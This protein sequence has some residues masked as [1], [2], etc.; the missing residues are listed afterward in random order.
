MDRLKKVPDVVGAIRRAK[1]ARALYDARRAAIDAHRRARITAL[2]DHARRHAPWHAERLA[3]LAADVDVPD[4]PVMD[5]ADLM[6]HFDDAVCDR[7]LRLAR[8]EQHIAELDRDLVL[9]GEYRVLA[10]SG[11][12]GLRGVYVLD[13][14]A[15]RRAMAVYPLAADLH[16]FGP[17]LPR[18]RRIAQLG[19]AGPLH[20]THRLT[21]SIDVGLNRVLRLDVTAP[22]PELC[23]ALQ[24]FDPEVLVGYPSVLAALADEQLD[25]RLDVRPAVV[26]TSSEQLTPGMRARIAAAWTDPFDAYATT[27]SAGVCAIEC[28]EHHGLHVLED[29]SALEAVD[30][31]DRPVPDG[32]PGDHVLLTCWANHVQPILRYRISDRITFA[33]DP[34]PC[35]RAARLIQAIEGRREDVLTFAGTDGR[36]VPVHPNHFEEPIEEQAGVAAYQVVRRAAELEVRVVVRPGSDPHALAGRLTTLLDARLRGLGAVPPPVVVRPVDALERTG[37][38]GKRQLVRSEV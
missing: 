21:T 30:A 14:A 16:G 35:G 11:T 17:R 3:H 1:E 34:C 18:R 8:L 26:G 13:R 10:S 28:P 20:M 23:R 2:V 12:S 9:D 19:A 7:R 33:P 37:A 4:L 31:D 15:F 38:S 32:E 5:K 24:A 29:V 36:P 6:A 25:G 27:E 22:V